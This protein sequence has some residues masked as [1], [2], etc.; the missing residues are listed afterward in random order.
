[1]KYTKLIIGLSLA[2]LSGCTKEE[3]VEQ[4]VVD[5]H[6]LH[7][8]TEHGGAKSTV[9]GLNV[10]W[11]KGDM[12]RVNKETVNLNIAN[13]NQELMYH[14]CTAEIIALFPGSLSNSSLDPAATAITVDLP[15]TYSYAQVDGRQKLDLPMVGKAAANDTSITMKHICGAVD[16]TITNS[17]GKTITLDSVVV[18]SANQ[19]SG[20]RTIS[21]GDMASFSVSPVAASNG[22]GRVKVTGGGSVASGA[23]KTIQVPV[24]PC[25]DFTVN[26]YGHTTVPY[27]KSRPAVAY[28]R[29]ATGR[30]VSRAM[31]MTANATISTSTGYNPMWF[32]LSSS[33]KVYF[34]E[35]NCFEDFNGRVKFL[36]KNGIAQQYLELG[37][38]GGSY[39]TCA[40]AQDAVNH[41]VSP[42]NTVSWSLF[43]ATEW[44]YM[45]K[46]RSASTLN[47]VANARYAKG[48]VGWKFGSETIYT[49]GLILF[50]DQYNHPEGV[51]LPASESINY[52]ASSV[53]STY[54]INTY[55]V[56]QW[57]KMEQ[58]GAVF[59]PAIGYYEGD[60]QNNY[61]TAG[62]Y[63]VSNTASA[64]NG[65]YWPVGWFWETNVT[66][67]P[68]PNN[69]VHSFSPTN[70]RCA[71][72]LV[73]NA[74]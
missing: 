66:V 27:V 32:S 18:T 10:Y 34:A 25:S 64:Q 41:L 29:T 65:T 60:T 53:S 74:N 69:Y 46:T 52:N 67:A 73:C 45:T 36:T 47:G 11:Q 16:V 30:T 31:V 49:K 58:A 24:L 70:D 62:Y 13:D 2:L 20:T 8:L 37:A 68:A 72:R 57:T 9:S 7:L 26:I 38:S 28:S 33:R 5:G 4:Q 54:T 61:E 43:T 48:R 39:F 59:L 44:D 40:S 17:T 15:S 14:D 55:N 3:L 21:V 12:F 56:D 35:A 23:T 1:M 63:C 50:P 51:P 42:F 71:L 6:R 19:L 22:N